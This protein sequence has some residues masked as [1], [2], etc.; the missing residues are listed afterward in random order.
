MEWLPPALG[1]TG[2]IAAAG[3]TFF[4]TRR[5]SHESRAVQ[6]QDKRSLTLQDLIHRLGELEFYARE[7][8][9]GNNLPKIE[10]FEAQRIPL[11]I[12][13]KKNRAFIRDDEA[14]ASRRFLAALIAIAKKHSETSPEDRETIHL[15]DVG[16]VDEELGE[17]LTSMLDAN[18][19]L[20][21][22]LRMALGGPKHL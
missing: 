18:E 1:L 10:E 11:N 6:F 14:H 12:F 19:L 21:K 17:L 3:I 7:F 8:F 15:T 4:S 20:E 13:L 9:S 16:V 2:V 5:T 22:R